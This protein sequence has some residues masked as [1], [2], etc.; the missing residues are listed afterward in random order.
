MRIHGR[1]SPGVSVAQ[2]NAAVAA[3][4]AQLARQYPA[5]NEFIAA[6]VA[7]YF[8]I[9]ALEGRGMTL[10]ETAGLTLTGLI[11]LV[12][13][14]NISG[15]MLV[16]SALRERELSIRQAIG[17]SRWRLIRYLLA[18]SVVLAGLGATLAS[19]VLFRSRWSLP[20]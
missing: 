10:I 13:C 19:I 17:A 7:P 15:M 12:V 2:A 1:L 8:P 9:G 6:S 14:L 4:T 18:E 16:R 3:V 11:L 20:G 5:T